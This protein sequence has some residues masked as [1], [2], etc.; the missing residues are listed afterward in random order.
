M[1]AKENERQAKH[2]LYRV[3]KG[4]LL[5]SVVYRLTG[6]TSQ[7]GA[8]KRSIKRALSRLTAEGLGRESG[9]SEL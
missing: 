3:Q 1:T 6:K 8:L 7:P 2:L 4:G 5:I 9:A